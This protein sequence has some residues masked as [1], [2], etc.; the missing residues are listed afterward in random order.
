MII[1]RAD[2]VRIET[3]EGG[4]WVRTIASGFTSKEAAMDW[5]L[6]FANSWPVW[7]YGT[8]FR[9][10]EQDGSYTVEASRFPSCD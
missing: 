5:E 10:Y 9:V 6:E 7:G 1:E 2:G 8:S 3:K 4:T